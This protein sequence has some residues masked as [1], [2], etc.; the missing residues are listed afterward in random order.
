MPQI[1]CTNLLLNFKISN[2]QVG[3]ALLPDLLDGQL[4]PGVS[5]DRRFRRKQVLL[6]EGPQRRVDLLLGKVAGSSEDDERVVRVEL[7][8][9]LNLADFLDTS[10]VNVVLNKPKLTVIHF[11]EI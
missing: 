7:L 11:E 8:V 9:S 4:G 6:E 5:D 10:Y 2:L 3:Q 1:R